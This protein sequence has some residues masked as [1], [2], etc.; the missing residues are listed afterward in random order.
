MHKLINLVPRNLVVT[1]SGEIETCK[2]TDQHNYYYGSADVGFA[3]C[4]KC[5]KKL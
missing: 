5:G 3:Y 1:E 2:H 4:P